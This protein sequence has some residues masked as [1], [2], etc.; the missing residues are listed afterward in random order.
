MGCDIHM[1]VERKEGPF[2]WKGVYGEDLW[3]EYER[4]H[5]PD[6]IA[7]PSLNWLYDGRCYNLFALLADVRNRCDILPIDSPRGLPVDISEDI[8]KEYEPWQWDA[9]SAS[10]FYLDELQEY[11]DESLEKYFT[12]SGIVSS[13]EYNQYLQKGYPT[14]YCQGVSGPDVKIV[15]NE[16]MMASIH[17]IIDMKGELYTKIFWIENLFKDTG[18]EEIV[19]ELEKYTKE[20][21][22]KSSD[23]RIVFWFDN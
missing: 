23:L 13:Y 15:S 1:Y 21:N 16:E 8:K 18:L 3:D 19:E 9:H 11:R 7:K 2:C 12:N 14:S 4:K 17:G 6:F 20:N 5:N 22:I 10:F